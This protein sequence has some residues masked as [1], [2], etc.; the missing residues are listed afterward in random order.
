M[1]IIVKEGDH[2]K[3]TCAAT[4]NPKPQIS[5]NLEN[6]HAIP[7]GAWKSSTLIFSL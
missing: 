3:L 2:L 4:G 1:A 5:W 6:G 7:D